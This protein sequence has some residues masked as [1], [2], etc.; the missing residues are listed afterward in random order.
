MK[1]TT[2]LPDAATSGLV[3][4]SV[5]LVV[6]MLMVSGSFGADEKTGGAATGETDT[7]A[8]DDQPKNARGE[9]RIPLAVARDR[10]VLMHQI[11]TATLEVMHDRYFHAD[12]SVIPARAMEDVFEALERETGSKANWISV[13]LKAMSVNHDPST[14]FEKQ[15]AR[16]LGKGV[17]AYE[18][19]DNGVYRRATPIPLHSGCVNCHAGFNFKPSTTPR[20][21]GLVISMPVT[22]DQ[23]V[24]P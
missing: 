13:N 7:A 6:L 1:R 21:A 23:S 18:T 20:L 12:R 22:E 9:S 17:A 10:A 15:A 11:Y 5:C 2:C 16:E 24:Q 3:S 19:V 4:V 8:T 14:E